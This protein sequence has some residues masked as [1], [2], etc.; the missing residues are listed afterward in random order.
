MAAG[1]MHAPGGRRFAILTV[2]PAVLVLVLVTI[3][4]L[5]YSLN[6]SFMQDDL[7]STVPAHYNA[8]QNYAGLIH[9]QLFWNSLR[10]TLLFVAMVLV[11]ELPLGLAL[12]LAV[13]HLPRLQQLAVTL[14]LIPSIISPSVIAFQWR[15]LFDYSAGPLNFLLAALDLPPQTWTASPS[16]ALPS[17]LLVDLWEWTPF[18][19]LILFAGL[20]SLP[21]DVLEASRVDG[22]SPMQVLFL[23]R[24]PL[25]RR[26]IAI[27]VVLRLLAAF[28][29]FDVIYT[30]TAG[31]PGINTESLAYYTYV[32]AFRYFNIGYSAAMS[33][34]G[35]IV[36]A[37]LVRAIL[38]AMEGG[39]HLAVEPA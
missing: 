31:G 23:Q 13:D 17:L 26:V 15:Q 11:I 27:A 36:V 22:S 32:Q 34:L 39:D 3:V 14:L 10:V 7:L 25:L 28:K 6:T 24:I 20:R 19:V 1:A 21:P 16:L 12:A 5:L 8:G 18:M 29:V 38:R 4:P 2:L 37:V 35:L 33:F 9:D 30:L